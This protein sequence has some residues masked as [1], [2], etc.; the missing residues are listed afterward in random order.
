[1]VVRPGKM[2]YVLSVQLITISIKKV[3]AAV[4]NQNVKHST[5]KSEFVKP[6]IKATQSRME[7]VS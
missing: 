5:F 1:M 6:A 4:S 3:S 2:E 7:S